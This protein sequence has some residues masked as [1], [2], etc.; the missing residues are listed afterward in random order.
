MV[1]R[2]ADHCQRDTVESRAKER[3]NHSFGVVTLL[4]V[5][6][7]LARLCG[8]DTKEHRLVLEGYRVPAANYPDATTTVAITTSEV[9][10]HIDSNDPGMD[11]RDEPP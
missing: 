2:V 4:V 8:F 9:V 1:Q 3:S 10:A 6:R 5:D 7:V 11:R